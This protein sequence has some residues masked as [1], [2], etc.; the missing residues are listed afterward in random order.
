M[1]RMTAKTLREAE[2]QFPG[3]AF[4]TSIE[5]TSEDEYWQRIVDSGWLEGMPPQ[6]AKRIR[7]ELHQTFLAAP[8][9]A[10]DCLTIISI[11]H[12]AFAES[13]TAVLERLREKSWGV[14]APGNVAE[15]EY[16]D[17]SISLSFTHMGR[18]YSARLSSARVDDVK[19]LKLVNRA[20][21]DAGVE[22]QFASLCLGVLKD[23]H[24]RLAFVSEKAFYRGEELGLFPADDANA[25]FR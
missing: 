9:L 25:F 7:D 2:R 22:R 1:G 14:F 21:R 15:T 6:E 23:D 20:L 11:D 8:E 12:T 16:E 3:D 19:I 24:I 10:M 4:Y 18:V 13:Y 17:G 5:G